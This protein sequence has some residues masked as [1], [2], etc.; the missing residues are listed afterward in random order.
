MMVFLQCSLN[1]SQKGTQPYAFVRL[2]QVAFM[3]FLIGFIYM[4]LL[5][6]LIKFC[7]WHLDCECAQPW[8]RK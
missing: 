1:N 6:F 3:S 2:V 7:V 4:V 5:R 8:L